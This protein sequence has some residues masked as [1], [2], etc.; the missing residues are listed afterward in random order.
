[1]QVCID[2]PY[3]PSNQTNEYRLSQWN[4][5]IRGPLIIRCTCA[6]FLP[7]LSSC[8]RT[9]FNLRGYE[10][11]TR[12]RWV[13]RAPNMWSLTALSGTKSCSDVRSR[14]RIDGR[15]PPAFTTSWLH[16]CNI[17]PKEVFS[18]LHATCFYATVTLVTRKSP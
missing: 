13:G 7:V 3:G 5:V 16:L 15:I 11:V 18:S 14:R 10:M 12:R 9:L 17:S 6:P 4:I 8:R 2:Y 1:M